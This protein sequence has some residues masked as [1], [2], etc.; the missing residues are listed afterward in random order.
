MYARLVLSELYTVLIIPN[1]LLDRPNPNADSSDEDSITR[2][3]TLDNISDNVSNYNQ[4]TMLNPSDEEISS[5]NYPGIRRS[6]H[7]LGYPL[8]YD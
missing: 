2:P 7:A 6:A 8:Y 5:Y 1:D 4:Q 3:A